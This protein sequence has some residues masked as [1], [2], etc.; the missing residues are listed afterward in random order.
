VDRVRVP[1]E[2]ALVLGVDVIWGEV[3]MPKRLTLY[4]TVAYSA[5][6][7]NGCMRMFSCCGMVRIFL[8]TFTP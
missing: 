1:S 8:V 6:T 5:T 3:T 2:T 7:E 4:S